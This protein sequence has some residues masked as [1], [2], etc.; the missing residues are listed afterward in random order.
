MLWQNLFD[1]GSACL[2]RVPEENRF[3]AYR[4]SVMTALG[5]ARRNL[6]EVLYSNRNFAAALAHYLSAVEYWPSD[7]ATWERIGRCHVQTGRPA[8]ARKAFVTALGHTRDN[9]EAKFPIA[10]ALAGTVTDRTDWPWI[11]AA[12]ETDEISSRIVRIFRAFRDGACEEA[13]SLLRETE[14]KSSGSGDLAWRVHQELSS[15]KEDSPELLSFLLREYPSHRTVVQATDA[16]M[17][18]NQR[19]EDKDEARRRNVSLL[20]DVLKKSPGTNAAEYAAFRLIDARYVGLPET[21]RMLEDKLDLLSRFRGDFP[22]SSLAAEALRKE[23]EIVSRS[24][25]DNEK[26]IELYTELVEKRKQH[27][28]VPSLAACHAG[29]G[30]YERA[31]S[32]LSGY[33][34]ERGKNYAARFQLGETFLQADMPAEGVACLTALLDETPDSGMK[35]RIEALLKDYTEAD[36]QEYTPPADG[37]PSLFL[38]ITSRRYGF[39]SIPALKKERPVITREIHEVTFFP[40]SSEKAACSFQLRVD[41]RRK[42]ALV[43]PAAV[44]TSNA[45]AFSSSWEDTIP[46]LPSRWKRRYFYRVLHPWRE[47]MDDDIEIERVFE[48]TEDRQALLTV[49]TKVPSPDWRI[50]ITCPS[51]A[52]KVESVSP[53]PEKREGTWVL[54]Y[55]PGSRGPE[56]LIVRIRVAPSANLLR[57][58]PKVRAVRNSTTV[59]EKRRSAAALEGSLG[60]NATFVVIPDRE[61]FFE[62]LTL[63]RETVYEMDE[64]IEYP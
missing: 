60:E 24:F 59:E 64:V 18:M 63:R 39:T 50:E 42:S 35:E 8:D 9:W 16:L 19:L 21:E 44:C 15:R 14:M 1:T 17:R 20:E 6:G 49:R 56:P 43:E 34:A 10:A 48:K 62:T 33:V 5:E 45:G 2:R 52:G 3:A 58:L 41:A 46:S 28:L 13:L 61:T 23:A 51:R 12:V 4:T 7:A 29:T 22:E 11:L 55:G 37:K 40:F 27:H 47:G 36:P 31:I 30:D 53:E 57:C 25:G 26:G 54:V 38:E 32:L